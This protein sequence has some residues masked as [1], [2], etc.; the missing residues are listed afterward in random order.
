MIVFF[1]LQIILYAYRECLI[2]FKM[3]QILYS[4]RSAPVYSLTLPQ[5]HTGRET[6]ALSSLEAMNQSYILLLH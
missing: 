3:K 5:A 4:F 6:T 1:L 2:L